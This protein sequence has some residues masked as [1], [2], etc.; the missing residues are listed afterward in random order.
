MYLPGTL[1]GMY[2]QVYA[3]HTPFVGAPPPPEHVMHTDEPRSVHG[4]VCGFY[5]FGREVGGERARLRRHLGM[6]LL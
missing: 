4:S 1:V 5:T 6:S 3:S 2:T